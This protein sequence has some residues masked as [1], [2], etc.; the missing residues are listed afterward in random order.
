LPRG[1]L[2]LLCPVNTLC[3]ALVLGVQEQRPVL[4]P[5]VKVPTRI[6]VA[7]V[8]QNK[9][10]E[11]LLA[12]RPSK[13]LLGGLWEFPNAPIDSDSDP[14]EALP[15]VI[16]AAYALKVIP[17]S[18]L[19]TVKHAYTHFKLTQHAFSCTLKG[20]RIGATLKWIPVSEL[21][22]YPMGKVDRQIA[23]SL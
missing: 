3:K 16:E 1:P 22:Q 21:N 13:G 19:V 5:K 18:E 10:G 2:C 20:K 17:Q 4:K 6:H 12:R 9:A 15:A 7:A 23:R 8:I 14:A 11:V